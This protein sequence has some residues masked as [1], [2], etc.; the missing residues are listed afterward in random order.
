M[1]HKSRSQMAFQHPEYLR[2]PTRY[3]PEFDYYSLGMV[4]LEIGFW[5]PLNKMTEEIRGSHE[6][7]LSELLRSRLPR[8]GQYMGVI[9]RDVVEACLT[10]DTQGAADISSFT[11]RVVEPLARCVI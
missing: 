5:K 9:F 8:L 7:V 4:L 10:W 3:C 1:D 2:R 11:K 6:D